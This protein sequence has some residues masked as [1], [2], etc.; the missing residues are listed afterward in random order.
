MNEFKEFKRT[1][2]SEMRKVSEKDINIFKNHGFIHISEYP[3]GNNISISDAD[4]NNG[5]PKICDMIARNPKD[6][7]D[8]W[9]VAEQY[10]N[11]NFEHSNQAE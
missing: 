3:F 8:Q 11:D 9:L 4:K 6:Y 2:I 1:Q 7:S 5:S 10:F